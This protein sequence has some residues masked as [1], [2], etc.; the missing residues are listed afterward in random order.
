MYR[1]DK[2]PG[3]A[4]KSP[5]VGG[6]PGSSQLL[7]PSAR[8]S[9]VRRGGPTTGSAPIQMVKH[10]T[11]APEVQDNEKPPSQTVKSS[12]PD[13]QSANKIHF[14][15]LFAE[16]MD[17]LGLPIMLGGGAAAAL[18]GSGRAIKDLDFKMGSGW[19]QAW[20]NDEDRLKITEKIL[21]ALKERGFKAEATN[22]A[23]KTTFPHVLRLSVLVE[24]GME[25]MDVSITSTGLYDEKGLVPKP[26]PMISPS[27]LI[28]DKAF[29]FA[30]RGGSDT[31]KQATDLV[32]MTTVLR[33][34]PSAIDEKALLVRWKGYRKK[35]RR[36]QSVKEESVGEEIL[37]RVANAHQKVHGQEGR[38]LLAAR[39][40]ERLEG[41]I[42]KG[43][44]IE[45]DRQ[46]QKERS[47]EKPQKPSKEEATASEPTVDPKERELRLLSLHALFADVQKEE[48]WATAKKVLAASDIKLRRVA[49]SEALT[50]AYDDALRNIYGAKLTDHK[51]FLAKNSPHKEK[52]TY[53][54]SLEEAYTI[55]K[56]ALRKAEAGALAEQCRNGMAKLDQVTGD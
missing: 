37:N 3:T 56:L 42:A 22:A 4:R 54:K 53:A 45:Q 14:A 55:Q 27:D 20:K 30:E 51:Q 43:G 31:A 12:A 26:V 21:V 47:I 8:P 9:D 23:D 11:F 50:A 41:A 6:S 25:P 52:S 10:V 2:K 18:H 46:E 16:L 7:P 29:A 33:K 1:H 15:K 36:E 38:A 17:K 28:M 32:D 34:N 13:E 19:K 49:T 24:E 48:R 39:Y 40:V 35:W 44:L 5:A